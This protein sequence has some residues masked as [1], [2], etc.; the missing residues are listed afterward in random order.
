LGNSRLPD[1][2][3][4]FL[5]YELEVVDGQVSR[6]VCARGGE[7]AWGTRKHSVRPGSQIHITVLAI[8]A[9]GLGYTVEDEFSVSSSNG[10]IV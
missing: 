7:I 9:G 5:A 8:I 2:I 10:W 6:I 4:T 1:K 3:C